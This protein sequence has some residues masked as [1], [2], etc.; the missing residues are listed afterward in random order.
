[1]QFV[2][3]QQAQFVSDLQQ[4]RKLSDRRHAQVTDALVG[5]ISVVGQVAGRVE[6]L[7]TRHDELAHRHEELAKRHGELAEAQR[8]TQVNLNALLLVVD[9][10]LRERGIRRRRTTRTPRPLMP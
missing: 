2:L 9:K 1:V 10:H 6:A 7:A 4:M 5:L 3:T 8:E